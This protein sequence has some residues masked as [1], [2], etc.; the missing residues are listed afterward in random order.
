VAALCHGLDRDLRHDL[1]HLH[2]QKEIDVATADVL[3]RLLPDVDG[4]QLT[5]RGLSGLDQRKAAMGRLSTQ[6]NES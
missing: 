5:R 3:V 2:D 6:G 4:L 1:G